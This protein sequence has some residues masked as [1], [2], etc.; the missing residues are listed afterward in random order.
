[1][2]YKDIRVDSGTHKPGHQ[3]VTPRTHDDLS[4]RQLSPMTANYSLIYK[5]ILDKKYDKVSVQ[6]CVSMKLHSG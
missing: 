1:M 6:P 3:T 2:R 5:S 4:K